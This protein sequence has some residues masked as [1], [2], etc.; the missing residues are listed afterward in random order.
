MFLF[1]DV[2]GVRFILKEGKKKCLFVCLLFLFVASPGQNGH[3]AKELDLVSHHVRTRLDE[4]KRQEV[5]RLRM[6]F[7]AKLDSTNVQSEWAGP[8]AQVSSGTMMGCVCVQLS[9]WTTPPS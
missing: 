5:S 7:K 8:G 4:L 9:R 1:M 2:C 6:L 3:L